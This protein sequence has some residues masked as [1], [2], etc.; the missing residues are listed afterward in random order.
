MRFLQKRLSTFILYKLKLVSNMI[1]LQI[2]NQGKL[3][4]NNKRV[5]TPNYI[6]QYYFNSTRVFVNKL[7]QFKIKLGLVYQSLIIQIKFILGI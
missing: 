4:I 2:I 6:L 1:A 7:S 5:R 3:K